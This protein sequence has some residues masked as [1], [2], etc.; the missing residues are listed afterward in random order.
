[1]TAGAM[2]PGGLRPAG[3]PDLRGSLSDPT[4]VLF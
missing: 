4:R 2:G 1:M 3:V